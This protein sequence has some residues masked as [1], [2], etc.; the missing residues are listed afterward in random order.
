MHHIHNLKYAKIAKCVPCVS[1]ATLQKLMEIIISLIQECYEKQL[2]LFKFLSKFRNST[3]LWGRYY[4]CTV[5][6]HFNLKY[7]VM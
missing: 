3:H 5:L 4:G 6:F 2:S 7:F 1:I